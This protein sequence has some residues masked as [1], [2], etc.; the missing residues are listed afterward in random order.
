MPSMMDLPNEIVLEIAKLMDLK[1]AIN[2][3][4][5]NSLPIPELR[6]MATK[7][8]YFEQAVIGHK[9]SEEC[10]FYLRPDLI[11]EFD[12]AKIVPGGEWLV[13]L[14]TDYERQEQPPALRQPHVRLW[15][16]TPPVQ[17]NFNCV[18]KAKLPTDYIPLE[19]CLQSGDG[20]LE[21]LVFVN[22]YR[23]AMPHDGGYIQV[24][25]ISLAAEDPQFSVIAEL[26]TD[27]FCTGMCLQNS[28][29]L[30]GT[31][32]QES[33]LA[34]A[35]IWDWKNGG[36]VEVSTS[37]SGRHWFLI[38]SETISVLWNANNRS[39]DVRWSSKSDRPNE[40]QHHLPLPRDT[41]ADPLLDPQDIFPV[42]H[43]CR[44]PSGDTY[45]TAL[46]HL[47]HET[48]RIEVEGLGAGRV[49]FTRYPKDNT[50]M[51]NPEDPG[52]PFGNDAEAPKSFIQTVNGHLVDIA[53][54]GRLTAYLASSSEDN[55]K[56]GESISY[57]P[58]TDFN[59]DAS[60]L[61]SPFLC[62]FSGV[63]GSVS[64]SGEFYI[65]RMD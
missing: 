64:E 30:V 42:I 43:E 1:D 28:N 38:V 47:E 6:K 18:A 34:N 40:E 54:S 15:Q 51:E 27:E 3:L 8:Y 14:S 58:F 20:P 56:T 16:I 53:S 2:L 59:E 10:P 26:K 45:Q 48:L 50:Y 21:L 5:L 12:D 52:D 24:L 37:E 62:P 25:R 57:F 7:P 33:Y 32:T 22:A 44:R 61:H 36:K 23:T 39:V 49:S 65:W 55:T 4:R 41:L 11:G 31:F 60:E 17:K 35:F 63:I 19:L 13:T 9:I 29:V 46:A